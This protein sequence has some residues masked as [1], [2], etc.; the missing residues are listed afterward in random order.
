MVMRIKAHKSYPE[1][2]SGELDKTNRQKI[3]CREN[4]WFNAL[5]EE[6][7]K[8][9]GKNKQGSYEFFKVDEDFGPQTTVVEIIERG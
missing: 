9:E 3:F 2:P 1:F 7:G 8:F 4:E 5:Q 6:F